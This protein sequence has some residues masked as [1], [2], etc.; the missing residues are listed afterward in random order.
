MCNSFRNMVG[1]VSANFWASRPGDPFDLPFVLDLEFTL[2]DGKESDESDDSMKEAH[3]D[4]WCI[5]DFFLWPD[6][7]ILVAPFPEIGEGPL[8]DHC[9]F[10]LDFWRLNKDLDY[11]E[12]KIK[13]LNRSGLFILIAAT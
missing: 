2:M 4:C 9:S 12:V 1:L 3:R 6:T 8:W 5:L 13:S 7:Q 10:P 11:L